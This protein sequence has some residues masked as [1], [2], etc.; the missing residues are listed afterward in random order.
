MKSKIIWS[1][2]ILFLFVNLAIS[3]ENLF[4]RHS[5]K[6]GIGVGINEGEKVIGMGLVYTIGY[7]KNFGKKEKLRI[8]PN[9]TFGSFNSN[10]VNDARDSFYQITNF[11]LLVNYDLIKYKSISLFLVAGGFANYTRG[12][13]GT[14]GENNIISSEYFNAFNYGGT[15]SFGIRINPLKSRISYE[16]KPMTMSFG[17]KDYLFGY[18]MFG[19]DYKLKK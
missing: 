4:S 10:Y 3:Q 6:T 8:A 17:N 1:F 12:M 5:I 9:I 16:I 14:G 2:Y 19:I 13:I 15:T 18:M 7:Q 11:G